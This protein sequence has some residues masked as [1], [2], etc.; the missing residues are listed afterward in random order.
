MK[1]T[2]MIKFTGA[3]ALVLSAFS[4]HAAPVFFVNNPSGNSVDWTNSVT[5]LGGAINANVNFNTHPLGPLNSTFYLASDGVTLATTGPWGNV[6]SDEA[7]Q[8]NT[9]DQQPGEGPHA[10]SNYLFANAGAK[11]LTISFNNPVL[12]V[13]LDTIDY[14][15]TKPNDRMRIEAFDGVSG[16]GNSL[17]SALSVDQNFQNYRNYFMGVSDAS[18]SIRSLVFSYS[19]ADTGDTIG[20]DDIRFAVAVPEPVSLALLGLGLA[21][22]GFTRNRNP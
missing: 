12:G 5:G 7:S 10:I 3:L 4:I 9:T 15:D 1:M 6:R 11:T 8:G 17:G 13:L 19:G 21:M 18:N 20:I 16:T 2:Q 22:L 14:F